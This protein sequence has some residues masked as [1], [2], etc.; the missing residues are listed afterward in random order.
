M[1]IG[2]SRERSRWHTNTRGR[3]PGLAPTNKLRALAASGK[4]ELLAEQRE[5]A[6]LFRTRSELSE[7]PRHVVTE[8]DVVRGL[9][10]SQADQQKVIRLV[11]DTNAEWNQKTQTQRIFLARSRLVEVL[12]SM[13]Y[14]PSDTRLELVKRAIQYWKRTW[15]TDYGKPPT[16]R[17]V[18]R[19]SMDPSL[20]KAYGQAASG[21]HKY[22]S[23][24]PDGHGG[25]L[26]DYGDGKGFQPGKGEHE[27]TTAAPT[28]KQGEEQITTGKHPSH[29]KFQPT[30]EDHPDGKQVHHLHEE[31]ATELHP[32]MKAKD[33]AAQWQK[34]ADEYKKLLGSGKKED[35]EK[36]HAHRHAANLHAQAHDEKFGAESAAAHGEPPKEAGKPPAPPPPPE[37]QE[38][39][40]NLPPTGAAGQAAPEPN[41]AAPMGPEQPLDGGQQPPMDQGAVPPPQA[42][43]PQPTESGIPGVQL[44]PEIQEVHG[45]LDRA[46][47]IMSQM[48]MAHQTIELNKLRIA[49]TKKDSSIPRNLRKRLTAQYEAEMAHAKAAAAELEDHHVATMEQLKAAQ[50]KLDKPNKLLDAFLK[51]LSKFVPKDATQRLKEAD[52]SEPPTEPG[53]EPKQ[54]KET[55]VGE[56]KPTEKSLRYDPEIVKSEAWLDT[57]VLVDHALQ[58]ARGPVKYKSRKRVGNRW[59]YDYGEGGGGKKT[60]KWVQEKK[61]EKRKKGPQKSRPTQRHWVQGSEYGLSDTQKAHKSG[62]VY[63]AQRQKLHKEIEAKFLDHV[64]PVPK[65][66]R[67]V[68]LV[69]MGGPASGKTTLVK[70]IQGTTNDFVLVNPD[71][72]KDHIPEYTKGIHLDEIDGVPVSA[73]DAAWLVHEESSDIAT[74]VMEKGIDQRKN[75]IIDGTGKNAEG[76]MAKMRR[77]KAAGY[78]IRLVM[79]HVDMEAAVQRVEDRATGSG[80]YVPEEI[81][82]DAHSK[83]PGNFFVIRKEAD[84]WA[85]FDNSG[86]KPKLGM[87]GPPP[88]EEDPK[89]AKEFRSTVEQMKAYRMG[90]SEAFGG[91]RFV[92]RKAETEEDD[93]PPSVSMEEMFRRIAR[94]KGDADPDGPLHHQVSHTSQ[95]DGIWWP[96]DDYEDEI[97]AMMNAHSNRV[98]KSDQQRCYPVAGIDRAH[99]GGPRL[100]VPIAGPAPRVDRAES[101]HPAKV[102]KRLV[103]AGHVV[104]DPT[105]VVPIDGGDED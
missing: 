14:I 30:V 24:K 26:Y 102:D 98:A 18:A 33:H 58:K 40:P 76:M 85:L 17:Y 93:L 105:F 83:V 20:H 31:V 77:L 78:H 2:E 79:P 43:E 21:S 46:A 60:P 13:K 25:W 72:V 39:G 71:D 41:G 69:T 101:V 35:R 49:R 104:A 87:W 23:R 82:R 84:E 57:I 73:R 6:K 29:D 96:V 68:A 75:V 62:G 80:R 19:K 90:K 65:D 55:A 63:S 22:K 74:S 59:V 4:G 88:T 50:K 36:A 89:F 86:Q 95:G 11:T 5:A 53:A 66:K 1:G 47:K 70:H 97:R 45:H 103:K 10:L 94:Y 52:K 64:P 27:G 9:G 44:S 100:V 48:S 92:I 7:P 51:V 42:A 67:P 32:D 34:H 54:D 38:G 81:V 28:K 61:Q 16:I 37:G 3:V 8:T 99:G 12:R 91:Q 56:E 15:Q